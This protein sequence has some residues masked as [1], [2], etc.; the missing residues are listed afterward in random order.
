MIYIIFNKPFNVLSQI[1]E[2][3][4][5][6][7]LKKFIKF[8]EKPKAVG[9]L[10]YDS[11]GL[12]ILT[13]DEKFSE[14]LTNPRSKIEKEYHVQVEGKISETDLLPIKNGITTN[15]EIY[16]P[17]I[18]DVLQ[19]PNYLWARNPPIRY[20]KNIPTSWLKL[21][22]KEGKN[23]MVRKMTAH[24]HFPTLRLIRYRIGNI[25]LND[26]EPGEF[27]LVKW[28]DIC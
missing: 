9:R 16:Q 4:D 17:A 1:K 18:A 25:T 11:E 28:Q 12:L 10:D 15:K 7:T 22:L 20:R 14:Y 24:I 8:K 6:D 2:M 3:D 5:K 19:E 26:L 13:D 23:R 21:I 27:K